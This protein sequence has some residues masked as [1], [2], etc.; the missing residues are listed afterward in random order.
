M[1]APSYL[2][3]LAKEAESQNHRR[4]RA[5]LAFQESDAPAEI[6]D[7]VDYGHNC[8]T[9][10]AINVNPS[11]V[12]GTSGISPS[13]IQTNIQSAKWNVEDD[14]IDVMEQMDLD[15]VT[16][17]EIDS[18]VRETQGKQLKKKSLGTKSK[19]NTSRSTKPQKTKTKK[20]KISSEDEM[21]AELYP[22]SIFDFS[23][24]DDTDIV[25][26][27][28]EHGLNKNFGVDFDVDQSE[29][30][31]FDPSISTAPNEAFITTRNVGTRKSSRQRT[32]TKEVMASNVTL[33]KR[34]RKRNPRSEQK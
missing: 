14:G 13:M 18:P 5:A 17:A 23:S 3:Q 15:Q 32:K 1:Q 7:I 22:Q 20:N 34:S 16:E 31:L 19:P 27:F 2:A 25:P 24:E 12:P 9:S 11:L 29:N 33:Q 10:E 8:L 28:K 4:T 21:D 26:N 6:H 30:D